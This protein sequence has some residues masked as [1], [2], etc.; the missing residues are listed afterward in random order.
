A[1]QAVGGGRDPGTAVAGQRWPEQTERAE[2]EGQL[3]G[4]RA[5]L[6]VLG[7]GGHDPRGYQLAHGVPDEALL[8]G[9]ELIDA[10]VIERC[11]CHGGSPR[12]C[13]KGCDPGGILRRWCARQRSRSGSACSLR[14][15]CSQCCSLGGRRP[16][17]TRCATWAMRSGPTTPAISRPP[18][19]SSHGSRMDRTRGS[20]SPTTSCGCAAW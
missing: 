11:V 7:D 20:R 4:K 10:V 6:P 16:A 3:L 18:G 1:D 17:L 9:K 2:L 12:G 14:G 15:R 13:G 19:P 5:L 8:V